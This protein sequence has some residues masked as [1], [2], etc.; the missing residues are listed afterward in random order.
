MKLLLHT[1]ALVALILLSSQNSFAAPTVKFCINDSCKKPLS[2]KITEDCWA[3]IKEIFATP[4]ST[5]KDEQDNIVNAVAL[6]EFDI[7]HSLASQSSE[8]NIAEDLYK[9]NSNRNNYLNIKHILNVLFDNYMVTRHLMRK[10]M[11]EKTWS[12]SE[13][14]GLMFQSLSSAKLYILQSDTSELGETAI[15]KPY[16]KSSLFDFIPSD[17][18]TDN[19]FNDDDF[20]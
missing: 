2:I 13:T 14:T 17:E 1:L 16:K 18:K 10:T 7:Y 11:V 19:T 4:F 3:D 6:I 15:I 9:K 5:D 12:G 20:E 8:K